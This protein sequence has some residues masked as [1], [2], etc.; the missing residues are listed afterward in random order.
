MGIEYMGMGGNVNVESHSRTSLVYRM[1][2]AIKLVC[3]FAASCARR[4]RRVGDSFVQ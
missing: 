3:F 4:P 1:P 2:T